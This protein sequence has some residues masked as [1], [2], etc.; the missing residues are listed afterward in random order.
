M[1]SETIVAVFDTAAHADAAIRDLMTAGIPASSIE[2]Y[3][4]DSKAADLHASSSSVTT[5]EHRGFW[6]WLT[7]GDDVTTDHHALYD[8]SI[9]SGGT[10][11]TVIANSAD[12]EGINEILDRHSPIDMDERH[13]QYSS[14]G[15]YGAVTAPAVA[16]SGTVAP[17]AQVTTAGGATEEVIS[18]S[19]ETLAVGKRE[20]DRGTTRVRRYVVERPIE[21]Q[22]RLR[23]ET[24]SVFRRPVTSSAAIGADAFTN[25]EIT[26]TE[27]DEEAVVAKSAHVVEEVVVQKGVEERVETIKDTLRREEVE[28]DGP[29]SG[30]A[31]TTTGANGADRTRMPG[32]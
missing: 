19:E 9:Q 29:N 1:P 32:I 7:G 28:I 26:M 5:N 24:V 15:S 4:Q 3:A 2:H 20:V 27:T 23:N 6:G 22:V 31:T 18:L 21:E 12:V 8:Q 13:S 16:T 30:T 10:V 25:R 14:S 11:V 17:S